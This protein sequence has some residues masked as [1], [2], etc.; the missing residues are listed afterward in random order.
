VNWALTHIIPLPA[1]H[2][3]S[4]MHII[5][6]SY[7]YPPD[8]AV[9][10][11]RA[12]NVARTF[13]DRGHRVTVVSLDDP[14][15]ATSGSQDPYIEVVRVRTRPS[16]RDMALAVR[17]RTRR[18]STAAGQG[19]GAA[20]AYTPAQSS[21]WRRYLYAL[22]WL[23]DD[24]IGFVLPA[25]ATALRIARSSDTTCVLYT[26]SPPHSTHLVGL[27]VRAVAG[28]PW[29][30]EYRDP[31]TDCGKGAHV[32][33][34]FTDW[35][36]SRMEA[37]CLARADAIVAVTR[38]SGDAF[39]RK[40]AQLSKNL[41]IHVARNG[42]PSMEPP[43]EVLPPPPIRL[44]HVGTLYGGRDPEPFFKALSWVILRDSWTP[45]DLC[46]EFV[47]DGSHHKGRALTDIAARYGLA[48]FLVVSPSVPH[49]EAL[50]RMKRS[51]LL[52]LLAQQQPLQVPNKLYEYVATRRPILAFADAHGETAAMLKELG[53]HYVIAPDGDDAA[54][55]TITRALQEAGTARA[56]QSDS[57]VLS[58]W[59][60]H[61]QLSSLVGM[62]EEL[63]D[64][65]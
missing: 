30:S 46:V 20:D 10:S 17:R 59:T 35:L 45:G 19:G 65:T 24:K 18:G 49:D 13:A 6:V 23:P 22:M 53:G 50:M 52:L 14:A 60:T 57:E 16:L 51:H 33:T 1:A 25:V 4:Q 12:C 40:A 43:S 64:A 26:T 54:H 61:A 8:P 29:I 37:A 15:L 47:G 39:R 28:L 3:P 41:R 9:G 7:H 62:A 58:R 56:V 36:E 34:R 32:R 63:N 2:Q 27:L 55:A 48:D 38:A 42:V 21:R 44:T 31:W 11:L 5:L